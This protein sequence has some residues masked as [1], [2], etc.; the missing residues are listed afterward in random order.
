[1]EI[2]K[3]KEWEKRS[4][5]NR[6][7]DIAEILFNEKGYEATTLDIIAK[8]AGYSKR[9]LYQYFADKN[10]IFNAIT[11][12]TLIS[13]NKELKSIIQKEITGLNMIIAISS[14]FFN[15]FMNHR[16]SFD[17]IIFFDITYCNDNSNNNEENDNSFG[18]KAEKIHQQNLDLILKALEIGIKDG[19]IITKFTPK[20]LQ[21][22]IW[23]QNMGIIHS[24]SRRYD[25]LKDIYNSTPRE[26]FT[27]YLKMINNCLQCE[28]TTILEIKL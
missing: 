10:D 18:S 19:S 9:N 15:Y 12:K 24:I 7:I 3:R 21:L 17:N 20:Q 1:M 13:L 4:K 6:I 14:T 25:Q 8:Q 27:N 28:I 5:Q 11:L 26:V 2:K 22:I 23:G 16:N